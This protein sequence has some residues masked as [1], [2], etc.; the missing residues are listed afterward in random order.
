M[1]SHLQDQTPSVQS[2]QDPYDDS[3]GLLFS[4]RC[5]SARPIATL[6][7]CLR[8]VSISSNASGAPSLASIQN[9][10]QSL[11][12]GTDRRMTQGGGSGSRGGGGGGGKMQYASVFVSD[13]GLTFQVHGVGKQSRA[14]VDLSAGLFSE[15]YVSEQTVV[16]EDD[17]DERTPNATG[18]DQER[19]EVVKGGE[20]GINLTT[21]LGCLLVLGPA[22]LDRT[23]LCLSYDTSAAIFKIEL[24]EEAGLVSG[25]GVII[26]NC[27]IP[28]MSV[29]DDFDDEEL[30]QESG[31]DYA[32]RSEPIVARARIQGDFLKA[33]IAE[34]T[35]VAGAVSVTVGIS[36]VGLELATFGHS[37]ECHVVVPYLGNHPEVFISLEGV[38]NDDIIHAR[39]YP[40]PSVL[41]GMRGLEIANETCISVNANGMIA[42]QHQVLDK[43]GNGDPNYIDFIMGCLQEDDELE[44]MEDASARIVRSQTQMSNSQS[45]GTRFS[46][47][48]SDDGGQEVQELLESPSRTT[49]AKSS[50]RSKHSKDVEIGTASRQDNDS[51]RMQ[52]GNDVDDGLVDSQE[53]LSQESNG[54]SLFGAVARISSKNQKSVPKN[55]RRNL[56]S[57]RGTSKQGDSNVIAENDQSEGSQGT[58][59][60]FEDSIDVTATLNM[61]RRRSSG[62]GVA[63]DPVYSPKL[64]YGDMHLEASDD[65]T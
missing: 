65:E 14:T 35:D 26:S 63:E 37:T 8:N 18:E 46:P 58:E 33:A 19:L 24:L 31:L 43:V 4:C 49:A 60:E 59:S 20:F 48:Y 54:P 45:A 5:E 53:T 10:T 62:G 1:P 7:S 41:S 42:I 39:S 40:M 22:S 23:T 50:K 27:A 44:E 61:S 56:S 47:S 34:L 57:T 11:L 30:G 15:F 13:K 3:D 52:K 38:G 25:G 9:V 16:V 55:T 21:V 17:E 32:F 51:S 12:P 6:L 29:E 36:K 64:M 2:P 28:G